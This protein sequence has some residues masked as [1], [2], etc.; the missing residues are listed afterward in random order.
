MKK[1]LLLLACI[2]VAAT[3][4]ASTPSTTEKLPEKVYICTGKSATVYHYNKNCKGIKAC[5][6][7]IKQVTLEEAVDMGRRPCKICGH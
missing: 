2:A 5:K 7:S 4:P 3:T 6:A 1:L